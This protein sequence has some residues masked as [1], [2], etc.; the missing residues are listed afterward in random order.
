MDA[1]SKAAS[2]LPYFYEGM[3]AAPGNYQDPVR[4]VTVTVELTAPSGRRHEAQAFWDGGRIWRFRYSPE[5]PGQWSFRVRHTAGDDTWLGGAGDFTVKPYAGPNPLYRHGPLQVSASGTHLT[6]ADGTPFFWLADTA[7]NG[8]MKADQVEW[9]HYLRVRRE[10]G[11]TAIQCVLTDWRA[12]PADVEGE[13]AFQGV[14][15]IRINP[16]FFRRFDHKVAAIAAH[17]LVP[18]LVV[19]WALTRHDPGN[20]LPTEDAV[21]LARYI[22]ARYGAYRPVWFL[23]GDGRYGG[24][25][26][27]R[28][29]QIGRAVFPAEERALVTL[30]P[31]GRQWI[32]EDFRQESWFDFV[33]YQSSHGPEPDTYRWITQ[34]PPADHWREE[35]GLPVINLEPC[36]EEHRMGGSSTCFTAHQVRRALY[37][38]LLVS[39]TAGVTYGHGSVWPW[40]AQYESPLDHRGAGISR[41]WFEALYTEGA[42]SVTCLKHFF[43]NLGWWKL[44]P[45]PHLICDQE[46]PQDEE[47]WYVP[48]SLAEDGS[49]AVIY[50]PEGGEVTL[51]GQHL[52][53]LPLRRWYNPRTGEWSAAGKAETAPGGQ[54][55]YRAPSELDWILWLGRA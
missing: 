32:G 25:N 28:W 55:R 2:P 9:D 13:G 26:A 51:H 14:R 39:P 6:H 7:W 47:R 5:E 50:L 31:C 43:D 48:A 41:P 24:L 20:Y 54:E 53:G 37:A 22:V 27:Q 30:H 1:R 29:R 23:G 4:D 45:A 11:F 35:P 15:D 21:L 8:V 19:L 34:G 17:G 40:S 33:G 36:Y 44:C 42:A 49:F 3:V 16:R 38:S 52:H 10:Q 18:A 12:W 46:A